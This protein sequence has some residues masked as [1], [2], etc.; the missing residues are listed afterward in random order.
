[1]LVKDY[2]LFFKWIFIF[3]EFG[4]FVNSAG[5]QTR[6]KT[7]MWTRLPLAFGKLYFR[8]RICTNWYCLQ[9]KSSIRFSWTFLL[10]LIFTLH[11]FSS[12][13]EAV[14][15]C[16]SLQFYRRLWD[17]SKQFA[18]CSVSCEIP[19]CCFLLFFYFLYFK[20]NIYILKERIK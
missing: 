14:P 15:F 17:S 7:L 5:R 16:N 1:M 12:L 8:L 9:L 11:F 4:V 10:Q 18:W 19:C 6:Q 3:T 20:Y 2:S 13:Q